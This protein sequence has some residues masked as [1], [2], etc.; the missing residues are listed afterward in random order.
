M[1]VLCGEPA[2]G[3]GEQHHVLQCLPSAACMLQLA[4]LLEQLLL[5]V[6]GEAKRHLVN[7]LQLAAAAAVGSAAIKPDVSVARPLQQVK[8]M[9]KTVKAWQLMTDYSRQLLLAA[10]MSGLWF[11]PVSGSCCGTAAG[12]ASFHEAMRAMPL[13]S[14]GLH[15][16]QQGQQQAEGVKVLNNSLF[17]HPAP[18]MA[19]PGMSAKDALIVAGVAAAAADKQMDDQGQ[20][21]QHCSSSRHGSSVKLA[22]QSSFPASLMLRCMEQLNRMLAE[23]PLLALQIFWDAWNML[24]SSGVLELGL[25]LLRLQEEWFMQSY[26]EQLTPA[27]YEHYKVRVFV[28]QYTCVA[29][30]IGSCHLLLEFDQPALPGWLKSNILSVYACGAGNCCSSDNYS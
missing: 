14:E 4:V 12:A 1:P 30:N 15:T 20:A 29:R 5:E 2:A 25:P 16:K 3:H 9:I 11:S 27:M 17:E 10:D 19:L 24:K 28:A 7:Q 13:H 18:A 22:L 6:K 23:L 26:V 21:Q 8:G